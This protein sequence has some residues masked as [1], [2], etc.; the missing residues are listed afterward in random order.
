[1][2]KETA[3]KIMNSGFVCDHC[4]GRQFAK[5][6][7]GYSNDQ[8]GKIIRN[9]LAMEYETKLFKIN[10]SNL[11]GLEFRKRKIKARK[12]GKC[13]VCRNLFEELP[14]FT[15][16]AAKKLKALDSKKFM[17]GVKMSD[18]LVIAEESLWEKSG[19]TYC[20]PIKSEIN[21]E[22]GKLIE[23]KTKKKPDEKKPDVIV[24]LDLQNKQIETSVNPLY[25]YGAYKKLVRGIPQTRWKGYESVEDIIAKPFMKLTGASFHTMHAC[26][27]E[28]RQARCLAWRPFI[29][30]ISQPL[31]RGINLKEIERRINKGK[32]V[33]VRGMKYSSRKEIVEMKK[34]R[35][36]KVYR[37][38]AKFENPVENIREVKKIIGVVNQRTPGRL[39]KRR[40]DRLRNKKVKS[41][42]WKKINT[43]SYEFEI[44]TESGL[45]INE[46]VS[47]D[48]GRTKPSISEILG[49]PAEVK[50]FD[51]V[52]ILM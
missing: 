17:V 32:K 21:R 36:E 31:K 8:R 33:K 35:V 47:G 24:L 10:T 38:L 4:L 6:L 28:D 26:G 1:M 22:L 44:H 11:Y 15:D 3:I 20:E 12:P 37:M 51:V 29:L 5:L 40:S 41:I 25:V 18:T 19:I 48:R 52:K 7:S 50:R 45:Y 42:K 2:I 39:L 9:F 43:K 13:V 23:K 14:K 27:R 30:E 49:N 46:L 16:Q 34:K